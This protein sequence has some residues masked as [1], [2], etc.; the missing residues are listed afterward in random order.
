MAGYDLKEGVYETKPVTDD[1]LWAA[2]ACVFSSKSKNDSSYKY[3][4]TKAILDNLYNLIFKKQQ[5][6]IVL[7]FT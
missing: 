6:D 7:A 1:E 2:S 5:I 3:G 4:F